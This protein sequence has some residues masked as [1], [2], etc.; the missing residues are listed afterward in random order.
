MVGDI[1][2]NLTMWSSLMFVMCIVVNK[3]LILIYGIK[4]NIKFFTTIG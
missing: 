3:M 4:Y 1:D 2:G